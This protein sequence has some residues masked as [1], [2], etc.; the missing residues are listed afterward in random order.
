MEVHSLCSWQ[1]LRISITIV[2]VNAQLPVQPR[3]LICLFLSKIDAEA[4]L[5]IDKA[6]IQIDGLRAERKAW[7]VSKIYDQLL[8]LRK[9]ETA[10]NRAEMQK[11]E[12]R[13][14]EQHLQKGQPH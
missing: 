5:R 6:S 1:G 13:G 14:G 10:G 2:L 12:A 11:S 9:W 3:L 4:D 8:Y 7:S